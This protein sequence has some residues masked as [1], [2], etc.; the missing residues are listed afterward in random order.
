MLAVLGG[1]LTHFEHDL[2]RDT[3]NAAKLSTGH[4]Q[5]RDN[6]ITVV[7]IDGRRRIATTG[8]DEQVESS[9]EALA[10]SGASPKSADSQVKANVIDV[11]AEPIRV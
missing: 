3:T 9:V 7:A 11:A 2:I 6:H 5:P 10:T 1:G 8:T 4:R